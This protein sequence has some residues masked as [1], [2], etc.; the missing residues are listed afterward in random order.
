MTPEFLP[1]FIEHFWLPAVVL[2]VV[3]DA[4]AWIFVIVIAKKILRSRR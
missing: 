2:F 4:L 1:W 3:L